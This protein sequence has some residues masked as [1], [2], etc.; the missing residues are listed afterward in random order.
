MKSRIKK[1]AAYL[2]GKRDELSQMSEKDGLLAKL[3]LDIHRKRTHTEFVMV[4]LFT[5]RPVHPIN[6]D[7]AI[8]SAEKRAAV[9]Q[10]NKSVLLQ[11]KQLDREILD[12][13]IPSVS[14]IK[15]VRTVDNELVAF[16]GNGR[17][18]AL[19]SVFSEGDGIQIEVEEYCFNNSKKLSRRVNRIRRLHGF[20]K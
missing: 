10:E 6:R 1:F 15:V 20:I 3:V 8:A 11:Q 19:Q 12:K 14:A 5:L 2:W 9:L 4:E 17:L 16:E 18:S 13:Y 7:T